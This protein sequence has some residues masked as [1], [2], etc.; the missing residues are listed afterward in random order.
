MR[1]EAIK[2]V[3][4]FG[5]SNIRDFMVYCIE[6]EFS[7]QSTEERLAVSGVQPLFTLGS[8]MFALSPVDFL[9]VL[10]GPQYQHRSF[11]SKVSFE[12]HT[13]N[14]YKMHVGLKLEWSLQEK[15]WE[16]LPFD[17]FFSCLLM[18]CPLAN[19]LRTHAGVRKLFARGHHISHSVTSKTCTWLHLIHRRL[20]GMGVWKLSTLWNA[21]TS[22]NRTM[23][24]WTSTLTGKKSFCATGRYCV[25]NSL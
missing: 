8:P 11:L 16:V 14:P 19:N 17:V 6:G 1:R 25:F 20:C 5:A 3:L 22:S 10:W 24:F 13:Q 4:R 18:W 12:G 2:F 9:S 7:S 23:C 15:Y 21:C